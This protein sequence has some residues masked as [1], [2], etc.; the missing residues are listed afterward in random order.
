LKITAERQ[1]EVNGKHCLQQAVWQDGGT[2]FVGKYLLFLPRV[3]RWEMC[4]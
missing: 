3:A 2:T 1:E 4:V